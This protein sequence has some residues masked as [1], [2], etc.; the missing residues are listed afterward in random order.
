MDSEIIRLGKKVLSGS[1]I[2]ALSHPLTFS[3]LL[4]L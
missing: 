3:M 2:S 4:D 1:F